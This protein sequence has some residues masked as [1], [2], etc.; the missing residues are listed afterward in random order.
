MTPQVPEYVVTFEAA[1][2]PLI[3]AIALGLISIG[4]TR[5]E[6]PAQS[7][8]ATAGALSVVLIAWLAVRSVPGRGECVFRDQRERSADFA[9]RSADPVDGRCRRPCGCLRSIASLVSA[10][11]LHWIVAAQVY[12]IIGGIFLV[13]WADGRLPWQFALPAG[14]GDVMTGGF[15][16]VVAIR[17]AQKAPGAIEG[18]L[19]LV[20]IW[21]RRPRRGGGHG[22]DD[23]PGT[24]P[25]LGLRCTGSSHFILSAGDDPYFRGSAG[26]HAPRPGF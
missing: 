13:L 19:R 23:V 25:P 5:M 16:I 2:R 26:S 3:A 15:A 1:M 17:L 8:Y 11:P 12:R 10:I 6:G 4:A 21:N 7:R 22:G 18:G 9:V 20:L 24:S 14:I